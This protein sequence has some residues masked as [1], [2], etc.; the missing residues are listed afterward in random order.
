LTRLALLLVTLLLAIALPFFVLVRLATL[1]Y[2]SYGWP[3]WLAIAVGVVGASV[4]ILV[5]A[6]YFSVR[7][8]FRSVVTVSRTRSAALVVFAYLVWSLVYV[9]AANVKT[10][11]V[12]ATYTSTHP[13]LRIAVAT[14][15]VFDRK[16]VI[17]DLERSRKDYAAMGLPARETSLHYRQ[18]DGFSHA[19]DLRTAGRSEFRNRFIAVCLRLA[20]LRTLRHVGTADHLHVS[21]PVR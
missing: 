9:S 5:Y 21:L 2:L 18:P 1:L 7:M 8:G 12:R 13:V 3:Y 15:V 17:T 19:I 6:Q 10:D 20:G 16:A 14:L 11:E 4:V